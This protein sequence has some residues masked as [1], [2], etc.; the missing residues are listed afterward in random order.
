MNL[1]LT[2]LTEA[3]NLPKVKTKT[4]QNVHAH[5]DVQKQMLKMASQQVHE[6][7]PDGYDATQTINYDSVTQDDS[8]TVKQQDSI[9]IH[10]TDPEIIDMLKIYK[11]DYI[12]T[13]VSNLIKKD[14]ST[15]N[16]NVETFID[17]PS[18]T[19]DV[20]MLLAALIFLVAADI[21]L[22]LKYRR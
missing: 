10:L 11:E 7:I 19:I 2:P 12:S 4:K 16:N 18:S 9:N 14:K 5:A 1:S 6:T 13:F 15:N 17:K 20:Q 22:R 21:I 8:K 3:Y